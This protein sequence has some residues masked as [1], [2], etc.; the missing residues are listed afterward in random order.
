MRPRQ[1]ARELAQEQ[2][3]GDRTRWTA[4]GICK[5][6]DLAFQLL[7]ILVEQRHRPDPIARAVGHASN[8]FHPVWRCSE[9]PARDLAEGDDARTSQGGDVDEMCRAE[10]PRVP[11]A[12]AKN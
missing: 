7:S 3:G 10:L 6:G 12:V 5:V 8:V 11:E 2:C 1:A 4:S 9:Q